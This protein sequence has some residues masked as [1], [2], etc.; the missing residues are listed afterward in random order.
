M[1][2]PRGLLQDSGALD[3]LATAEVSA[4]S[5]EQ[6]GPTPRFLLWTPRRSNSPQPT[7]LDPRILAELR[8]PQQSR[9]APHPPHEGPELHPSSAHR[10][11]PGPRPQPCVHLLG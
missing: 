2:V 8:G 11:A 10:A 3:H 6:Q 1:R 4:P 7:P 5:A 9:Q